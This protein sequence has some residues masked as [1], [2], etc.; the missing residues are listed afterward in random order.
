ME[1]KKEVAG[2][3]DVYHT[4]RYVANQCQNAVFGRSDWLLPSHG[5]VKVAA[6]QF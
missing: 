4:W 5:L 2:W 3:K 6:S 1:Q